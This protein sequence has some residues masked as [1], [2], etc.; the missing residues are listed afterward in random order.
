MKEERVPVL[1][2]GLY[3]DFEV[4]RKYADIPEVW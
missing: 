3:M 4:L 1:F 2:Y